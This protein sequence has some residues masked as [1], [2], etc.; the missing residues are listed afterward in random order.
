MYK[1]LRRIDI[2]TDLVNE[3]SLVRYRV[4]FP[5]SIPKGTATYEIPFGAMGLN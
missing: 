5:T 4:L 2:S 3:E 1:G